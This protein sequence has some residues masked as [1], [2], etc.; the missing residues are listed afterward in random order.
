[1]T[2]S[3]TSF[4]AGD[5]DR[6]LAKIVVATDVKNTGTVAGDEVVQL[7][8]SQTGTSVA[9]PVRELKGFQRVTLAPGVSKHVEFTIGHDEL[10][11]WGLDMRNAVESGTLSIWVGGSSVGGEPK[12]VELK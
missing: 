12:T 6:G 7:Y 2:V 8:V 11:I 5:I 1:V 9:R 10:A 4:A 3:N